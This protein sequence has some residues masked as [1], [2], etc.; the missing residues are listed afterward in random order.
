MRA[1]LDKEILAIG[2]AG[3]RTRLGRRYGQLAPPRK[4]NYG[5]ASYFYLC[6]ISAGSHVG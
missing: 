5:A 3:H 4:Y 1:R 6:C 2:F